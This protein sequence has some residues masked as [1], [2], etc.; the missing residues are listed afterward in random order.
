M[1]S[2]CGPSSTQSQQNHIFKNRTFLTLRLLSSSCEDPHDPTGSTGTVQDKDLDSV[3][4]AESLCWFWDMGMDIS[5][6]S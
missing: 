3:T 6:E 1:T 2:A 4:V 5:A